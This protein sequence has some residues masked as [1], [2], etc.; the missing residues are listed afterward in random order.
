VTRSDARFERILLG[1]VA[2]IGLIQTFLWLQFMEADGISYLDIA[3]AYTDRDW[4][5][6]VSAYWSPLYSW[7]IASTSLVHDLSP[8][9]EFAVAHAVSFVGFL[10]ALAAFAFF[11]RQ[12][13]ARLSVV[14]NTTTWSPAPWMALTYGLFLYGAVVLCNVGRGGPDMLVSAAFYAAIGLLLRLHDARAPHLRVALCLGAVLGVGYLAK[15]IMFPIAFVVLVCAALILRRRSRGLLMTG[16]AVGAFAVIAVPW[17]AVLSQAKGR[18]TFSD[19]GKIVYS[20]YVTGAAMTHAREDPVHGKPLHPTR[21][22]SANPVIYE[23]AHPVRGTYPVWYDPSYWHDGLSAAPNFRAQVRTLVVSIKEILRESWFYP[24]VTAIIA[25][26][27]IGGAGATMRAVDHLWFVLVPSAAGVVT[28]C[29]VLV[30]GRYIAPFVVVGLSALTL[31]TAATFANSSDVKKRSADAV[32]IALA[33]VLTIM[34]VTQLVRNDRHLPFKTGQLDAANMLHRY[35]VPERASI[36]V[37]GDSMDAFWARLGR[38]HIVAEI[39]SHETGKFWSQNIQERNRDLELF[40]STG[41]VAV[42]ADDVPPWA[43][44]SGWIRVGNSDYW[45]HLLR[46]PQAAGAANGSIP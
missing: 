44:T 31:G 23:F 41:A 37:I 20:S 3:Q 24:S 28:Y 30:L 33:S 45:V 42:V 10:L 1:V 26:V 14:S 46:A 18:M 4:A 32:A 40:R 6:A 2:C 19:T 27:L 29:L 8:R 12:L 36:G 11:V 7:M 35:G 13:F 34:S 43:E 38:F 25:L 16:A 15:A 17:I 39:V 5:G 21:R 22:L 9:S